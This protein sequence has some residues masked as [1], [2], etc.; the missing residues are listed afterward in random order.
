[1]R[2]MFTSEDGDHCEFGMRFDPRQADLEEICANL[3]EYIADF[4]HRDEAHI[5]AFIHD[6]PGEDE[7]IFELVAYRDLEK[8]R[9]NRDLDASEAFIADLSDL[10]ALGRN[11]E[12]QFAE[13]YEPPQSLKI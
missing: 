11:L 8:L 13:K 3:A 12:D 7:V 1:M 5:C 4:I 9:E 2:G 6:L 10:G